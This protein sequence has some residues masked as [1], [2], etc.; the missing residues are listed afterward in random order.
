MGRQPDSQSPKPEDVHSH[1][2]SGYES[3]RLDIGSG[4][5]ERERTR[6]LLKRFLPP[7]PA[8]I[9][10]IGGGPGAH[11]CWLATIGYEVHVIDITPLHTELAK[12]ASRQQPEHPLASANVGDAR[13]LAWN[14]NSV[15]VV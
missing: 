6:E 4:Q 11:A 1:Y 9:L 2:A 10:D 8:T 12:E 15:D 3:Q 13:S 7:V 14:A 5:L